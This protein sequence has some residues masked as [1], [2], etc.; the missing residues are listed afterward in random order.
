MRRTPTRSTS[1][2]L[3]VAGLASFALLGLTACSDDADDEATDE[4]TSQ[5]SEP[6]ASETPAEEPVAEEE[7][8]ETAASGDQP[9]WAEPLTTPGEK[10]ATIEAGDI[11]IDVHQVGTT[12]ATKTGQFV[13][14]EKNKPIIAEGDE[15]VFVNYVATNNGEDID[16]GSSLVSV[17]A[18]YDDWPY[19]QGMDSIVDDTLFEQMEVN[20]GA[21]AVGAFRDPSVYTLGA[22]QQISWGENFL[23]QKGSPITF[24]VTIVPVDAEGELLHDDRIEGTGTAKIS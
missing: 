9:D 14:P 19:M 8:G 2:R 18:R 23:Y 11:S 24:E 22:G 15:I 17:E 12:K 3:A 21:L 7:E 13:D 10:I 1:A 16:L 4:P 5:P 6:A 20:D